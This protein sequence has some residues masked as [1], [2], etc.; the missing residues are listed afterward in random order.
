MAGGD[1][2]SRANA[3]IVIAAATSLF[4]AGRRLAGGMSTEVAALSLAALVWLSGLI[5]LRA[6]DP[7]GFYVAAAGGLL[8][9]NLRFFLVLPGDE[10]YMWLADY[11]A[12]V[13]GFALSTFESA[14]AWRLLI[15]RGGGR[16][17]AGGS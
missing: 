17:G 1:A 12:A 4:I 2:K 5:A 7:R 13:L 14:Q 3:S 8:F 15:R 6:G 11:V 16:V 10:G 9:L